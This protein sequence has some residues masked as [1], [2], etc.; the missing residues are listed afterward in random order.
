MPVLRRSFGALPALLATVLMSAAFAVP[1]GSVSKV[2]GYGHLPLAFER[3]T[4]QTDAQVKFLSR[5]LG[6]ALYL[7]HQ[8]AVLQVGTGRREIV[9]LTMEG[10]SPQVELEGVEPQRSYSS[11]FI[12]NDAAQWRTAVPHFG[13]VRYRQ[14]YPGVDVVFY[15]NQRQLEYDFIVAPQ[16]DPSRIRFKVEGA[17]H[18]H[19]DDGGSLIIDT[20]AGEIRQ[21]KP[22]IYQQDGPTRRLVGGSYRLLRGNRVAFDIATYDR[23]K[24][25]VVD[26]VLSYS[27]LLGGADYDFATGIAVDSSNCA[28]ITGYTHSLDFPTTTGA[29]RP[30]AANGS[31]QEAFVAKLASDGKSLIYA[32][33]LGGSNDDR[34]IGIAVDAFGNAYIAGNTSSL[35]FPTTSGAYSTMGSGFVTKLNDGGTQLIFS[36]Y[37]PGGGATQNA[38]AIDTFGNVYVTGTVSSQQFPTTPGAFQAIRTDVYANDAFV[39]KLGSSGASLAYSTLLGGNDSDSGNAIT[40]DSGGNAYIAGFTRSANFPTTSGVIQP[41]LIGNQNAFVT[42]LNSTGSALQFSTLL[43]GGGESATGVSVSSTGEILIAGFAGCGT[44]PTTAGAFQSIA[45]PCGNP[46]FAAKLS[47]DGST[48]LYGTYLGN[49][50][51]WSGPSPGLGFLVAATPEGSAYLAGTGT[52]PTL[53]GAIQLNP[54]SGSGPFI[55]KLDSTGGILTYSSYL[56]GSGSNFLWGM[57]LDSAWNVYLAGNTN[58]TNFPTTPGA[59]RT[60]SA[61]SQDAFVAK[62]DMNASSCSYTL[63]AAGQSVPYQGG[64]GTFDVTAPDGC[65]WI[66][67]ADPSITITAGTSGSGNGTVSYAVSA[68]NNTTFRTVLITLGGQTYTISQGGAPCAYTLQPLSRSF[69]SVGGYSSF[70]VSAP[71]GCAWTAVSG[72]DWV[73]VSGYPSGDGSGS[74]FFTVA[75]NLL[76]PRSASVSVAGQTFTVNQSGTGVPCTYSLATSALSVGPNGTAGSAGITAPAGCPWSAVSDQA[77]ITVTSGISGTGNGAVGYSVGVNAAAASRGG[78]I[79]IGGQ[80]FSVTQSGAVKFD[81]NGDGSADILW[82]D[83]VSGLAQVWFLSGAQGISI[84][85]AANLTASNTWRVVAVGDFNRDGHPDTVWQD[86]VTGAAQVWFLGGAQGNVFTSA[87]TISAGNSWRIMS[88]A[89]F[90]GDGIPDCIWQDQSSGWAQI[91]FMGG[92]QGTTVTGAVNLTTRNT[93]RIAGTGDFNGDG[94]PDVVWQDPVTGA[95]QI[96]YLGGA[97][98]NVVQNAVNLANSNSWKLAAIADFNGDGHPDSVWQDPVSGAAV[99]WFL[100]GAQGV[101]VVGSAGMGSS[102]SWRIMGPH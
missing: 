71:T 35:N 32:T 78:T 36:T 41:S 17:K 15:G 53:P 40:V 83:P 101:T 88:V 16:A 56:S 70:Y 24:S 72:A 84:A 96:W 29:Y 1:A 51:Y 25:L 66:T 52:V 33:Y 58:A 89:D 45:Q 85:G 76:A 6:Y 82:Q 59:F 62:L 98:G 54:P 14:I 93:W 23:S 75:P 55:V 38:M 34:P 2:E 87:A 7:T 94:V 28:Y 77:W 69:T 19:V 46:G 99:V 81:F 92:A 64:V 39:L 5:G 30:V 65:A 74:V 60:A 10:A 31:G 79:T 102:T 68:N 4:G 12:G 3:N 80:P 18:L 43:G 11:Y 42:K 73:T 37:T 13:Q 100:G 95:T 9:R 26:P 57:A 61:G 47:P 97:Q 21:L 49:L 44:F 27:T 48:L 8:G 63:S 22:T 50:A 20:S 86:P 67:S 90:N 91:W